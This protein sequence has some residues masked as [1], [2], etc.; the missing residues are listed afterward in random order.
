MTRTKIQNL[1]LQ[2]IETEKEA[3]GIQSP[4]CQSSSSG[5]SLYL[6]VEGN[7]IE[8]RQMSWHGKPY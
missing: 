4:P 1:V 8:E 7:S 6:G 3:Y 2:L 5:Y